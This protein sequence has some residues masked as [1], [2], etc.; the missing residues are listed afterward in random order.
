MHMVWQLHK[1]LQG[2]GLSTGSLPHRLKTSVKPIEKS[3]VPSSYH[4]I[5]G[6]GQ[7]VKTGSLVWPGPLLFFSLYGVCI[8]MCG[9]LLK[10]EWIFSAH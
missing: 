7:V 9:S 6:M 8:H 2:E 4:T 10:A 5:L 1:P 3:H